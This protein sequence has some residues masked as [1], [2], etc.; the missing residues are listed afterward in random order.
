MKLSAAVVGTVNTVRWMQ[1]NRPAAVRNRVVVI[2]LLNDIL[3]AKN[4]I[5]NKAAAFAF[6][7]NGANPLNR[8]VCCIR[9][10][11]GVFNIVPNAPDDFPQLPFDLLTLVDGIKTSSPFQPPQIAAVKRRG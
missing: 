10:F 2:A 3:L 9:E 5:A 11:A 8:Q 7:G 4:M 6:S 1:I